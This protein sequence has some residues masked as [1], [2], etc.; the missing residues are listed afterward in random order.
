M[1]LPSSYAKAYRQYVYTVRQGAPRN[2]SR[3]SK[4]GTNVAFNFFCPH[5]ERHSTITQ[6]SRSTA[7]H[8]LNIPNEV[9]RRTLISS[10]LVCPNPDCRKY[11]L[12]VS[13][14]TSTYDKFGGNEKIGE[15]LLD[16]RL[17]P[18]GSARAFPECVP[19]VL[20]S[21]YREACLIAD[22]S[23]KASAT[24]SRRALQGMIR[25]FWGIKIAK[26]TLWVE[27][28]AIEEK[29]DAETWQAIKAV[30]DLGNIGA[31]MQADI[32]VIV[33]VDPEEAKLLIG[34]T[35]TLFD[36]WYV[37]RETRKQK[38]A[39]IAAAA[40]AKILPPPQ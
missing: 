6:Q 22:L 12:N 25:D 26:P 7:W 13:L 17:E 35:E 34:L 4:G 28:K 36:E 2:S 23:P 8:T 5:C 19:E 11:T 37:A 16:V 18:Y 29:V 39:A 9:G 3:S 33:D 10:F 38:M 15:E 32:N 40:K 31:H 1:C 20:Q 24:L 27:I 14:H 30:K 21:D